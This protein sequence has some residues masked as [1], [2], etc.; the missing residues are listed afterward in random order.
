MA[1]TYF[2]AFLMYGYCVVFLK[3]RLVGVSHFPITHLRSLPVDKIN[4][5]T[6]YI[7]YEMAIYFIGK[8]S[9]PHT[10]AVEW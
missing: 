10:H 6:K 5:Q 9:L 7:S 8:P 3:D 4:R 1:I 2:E